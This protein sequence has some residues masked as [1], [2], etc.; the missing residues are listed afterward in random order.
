MPKPKT[1]TDRAL[2]VSLRKIAR[3]PDAT[4]SQRLHA[5]KLLME[6]REQGLNTTAPGR[7]KTEPDVP[8]AAVPSVFADLLADADIL[9]E[10][11]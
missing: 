11:K 3:D 10:Q 7:P 4:P 5:C 2:I 1:R 8:S 6:L 9:P